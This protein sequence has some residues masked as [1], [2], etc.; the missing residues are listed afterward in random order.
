[1]AIEWYYLKNGEKVGPI[2]S[3]ELKNLAVKQ[4]IMPSDLIWKEGLE[5][6]VKAKSVNGLFINPNPDLDKVTSEQSKS[7][8]P[9]D[10][11]PVSL[12]IDPH[13]N[14]VSSNISGNVSLPDL[15]EKDHTYP[16]NIVN[17]EI[18][19]ED[20]SSLGFFKLVS[21]KALDAGSYAKAQGLLAKITQIDIPNAFY[22]HGKN[23]YQNSNLASEFGD[24]FNKITF[25]SSEI[26]ECEAKSSS[27]NN[28]KKNNNTLQNLKEKAILKGKV[29]SL[30][31][32]KREIL[33]AL[34]KDAFESGI[35]IPELEE[36]TKRI[37]SL[38]EK[39]NSLK[40]DRSIVAD[41]ISNSKKFNMIRR[42]PWLSG[43]AVLFLM[44]ALSTLIDSEEGKPNVP[45]QEAID[46]TDNQTASVDGNFNLNKEKLSLKD[47]PVPAEEFIAALKNVESSFKLATPE[48]GTDV[49]GTPFE[50]KSRVLLSSVPEP[51]LLHIGSMQLSNNCEVVV[52]IIYGGP[53]RKLVDITLAKHM[54]L[55]NENDPRNNN[56]DLFEF[57]ERYLLPGSKYKEFYNTNSLKVILSGVASYEFERAYVTTSLSRETK[58]IRVSIARKP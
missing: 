33:R 7:I 46:K 49:N 25:I 2:S 8:N 10:E 11:I 17:S 4:E 50:L 1:M 3:T 14:L 45:G 43:I 22:E 57:I 20:K 58:E 26:E 36:S 35:N 52:V 42:H 15:P 27:N 19:L 47:A 18:Q 40:G 56:S 51:H 44:F 41:S 32:K 9:K 29:E 53:D 31:L 5:K 21:K 13:E 54:D 12:G 39:S 38:V 34:G 28:D 37:S 24:L 6:W 16:D 55:Q 23:I 30:K 48:G